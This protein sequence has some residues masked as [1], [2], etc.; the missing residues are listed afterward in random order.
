MDLPSSLTTSLEKLVLVSK[1]LSSCVLVCQ[2]GSAGAS[3]LAELF[4]A[5]ARDEA[6]PEGA[7]GGRSQPSAVACRRLWDALSRANLRVGECEVCMRW[8]LWGSLAVA[9]LCYFCWKLGVIGAVA[10]LVWD[11]R[12][13]KYS[14]SRQSL[15]DVI[16]II[17]SVHGV[18]GSFQD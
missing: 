2:Q 3:A 9:G 16:A 6:R 5:F 7:G 11:L 13:Y 1:R 10:P 8:Q 17:S 12:N 4:R 14:H 18:D 15:L